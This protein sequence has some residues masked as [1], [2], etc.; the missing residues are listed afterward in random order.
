LGEKSPDNVIF[1]VEPIDGRLPSLEDGPSWPVLIAKYQP[2]QRVTKFLILRKKID[3]AQITESKKI[4][5]EQHIFGEK[6]NVP[7]R[8]QPILS[9][10]EIRPTIMG[11]LA[12]IFFKPD[13]LVITIELKNGI[14]RQYRIVSD[15]AKS[16]F[17]IS[18][19]I[20][21][22]DNF[23]FLYFRNSYLEGKLVTSFSITS[24]EGKSILWDN[25]Y[26]VTF[27]EMEAASQINIKKYLDFDG[28]ADE[29][30][31]YKTS[32]LEKCDGQID[33]VNDTSPA[34]AQ[35]SISGLLIVRG[36]LAVS[37]DKG[38]LPEAVYVVLI[39]DQGKHFYLKTRRTPRLD[40]AA[41]FKKPEL[42]ESGFITKADISEFE[43][44][45]TLSLAV[46]QSNE[47]KICPQFKIRATITR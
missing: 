1:K 32:V 46:R 42:N 44:Q 7:L 31:S 43:G 38:T 9:E 29:L 36:W 13:Q 35:I 3:V 22:T 4:T 21:N 30:S 37:V 6:V 24:G 41:H 2:M 28:I 27:R 8:R 10:I 47:I 26:V 25:R 11:R 5:S 45:Y 34:P 33:A 18:P 19:L 40:V 17:L 14:K 39:N 16:G 15:M 23:A 20:E 12:N